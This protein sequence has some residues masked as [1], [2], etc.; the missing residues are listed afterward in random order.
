V[1]PG[2]GEEIQSTLLRFED[3][4]DFEDL[5]V[6][7]LLKNV[8]TSCWA[9]ALKATS[10]SVR[11]KVMDN[12][13]EEVAKILGDQIDEIQSVDNDQASQAQSEVINACIQLAEQGKI[14]LPQK[15]VSETE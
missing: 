15:S 8:D 12:M 3:L 10:E 11:K 4:Q 5:D 9:P 7:I 13:A 6:Q 2:L 1:E 14:V